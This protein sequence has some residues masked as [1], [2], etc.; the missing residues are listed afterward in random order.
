ME[1]SQIALARLSF[2]AF[3]LGIALGIL[4]DLIR[5]LIGANRC[6][7]NS[8]LFQS[9]RAVKKFYRK[10]V[11]K[12]QSKRFAV[13]VFLSDFIF[14]ILVA[15]SIILLFY[16]GNNGKWRF[17][18]VLCILCGAFLYRTLLSKCVLLIAETACTF[19]IGTVRLLCFVVL[20]PFAWSIKTVT[21]KIRSGLLLLSLKRE[22]QKRGRYTRA[23]YRAIE[24]NALGMIN[25]KHRKTERNENGKDKEKAI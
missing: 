6:T 23:L 11:K 21:R 14:C 24:Y 7:H 17:P 2:V 4:Y 1:I 8:D 5:T 22:Q 9:I 3:L 12:T 18:I 19:L 10:R 13:I 25:V 20:F 16:Q 15:I